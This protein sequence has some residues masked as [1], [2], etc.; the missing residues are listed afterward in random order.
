MMNEWFILHAFEFN[1]FIDKKKGKTSECFVTT[2]ENINVHA[3]VCSINKYVFFIIK[4]NV[5]EN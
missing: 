3:T 2:Q 1:A 5:C 4:D